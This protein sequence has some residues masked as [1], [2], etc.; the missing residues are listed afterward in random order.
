M[1]VFR[2][3]CI[4]ANSFT[5]SLCARNCNPGLK[6]LAI[7]KTAKLE[8]F[9]VFGTSKGSFGVF[10]GALGVPNFFV[11]SLCARNLLEFVSF[12]DMRKGVVGG[13]FL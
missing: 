1:G 10:R 9:R 6:L 11:V 4:V 7:A 8:F 5:A 13:E 2:G 3:T 12:F